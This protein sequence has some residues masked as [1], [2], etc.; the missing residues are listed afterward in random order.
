MEHL[1]SND[2]QSQLLPVSQHIHPLIYCMRDTLTK[3]HLQM[4]LQPTKDQLNPYDA[5][6]KCGDNVLW[7]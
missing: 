1:N 6:I 5:F 2:S 4:L 7:G 3:V